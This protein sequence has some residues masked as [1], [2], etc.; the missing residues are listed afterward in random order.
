MS[1]RIDSTSDARVANN[2]ARHEYRTL[3]AFE[4]EQVRAVKDRVAD[5]IELLHAIDGTE[6]GAPAEARDL[7]LA[8]D[9]ITDAGMRAVRHITQ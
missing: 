1:D 5:L 9:H 4:R 6:I 3:T 2:V 8:I 7:Q